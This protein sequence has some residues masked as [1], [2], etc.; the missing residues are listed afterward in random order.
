MAGTYM[1][2]TG[3][4]PTVEVAYQQVIAEITSRFEDWDD[5]AGKGGQ[6]RW[7]QVW[8]DPVPDCAVEWMRGWV[9][10]NP[11]DVLVRYARE[12]ARR[13]VAAGPVGQQMREMFDKFG[14]WLTFPLASGGW[15]FFGWVN[16]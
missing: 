13:E 11:P 2:E 5:P 1:A 14:P 7:I 12:Q 4:G 16:T 15:H 8:P 9:Q 6:M 10:Q 3:I